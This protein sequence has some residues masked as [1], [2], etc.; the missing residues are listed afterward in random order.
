MRVN[1]CGIPH[2]V[3]MVQDN[4]DID[5]HFAMID[6]KNAEIRVN[7]DMA[8]EIKEEAVCHEIIHGILTHIG[9]DNLSEDERL[10]QALAN[11]VNQ[12][13]AIKYES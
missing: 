8:R 13:F 3:K 11:A 6:Y 4:F 2:E 5:C 9:Y 10:V 1:I 12:A 7:K